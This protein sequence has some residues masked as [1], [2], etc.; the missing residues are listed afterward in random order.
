MDFVGRH[1]SAA[2]CNQRSSEC[3]RGESSRLHPVLVDGFV[4]LSR[5]RHNAPAALSTRRAEIDHLLRNR[6]TP[7]SAFRRVS[8][9]EAAVV[10]HGDR[11]WQQSLH[12]HVRDQQGQEQDVDRNEGSFSGSFSV[13]RDEEPGNVVSAPFLSRIGGVG[14]APRST[15]RP[16]PSLFLFTAT[17]RSRTPNEPANTSGAVPTGVLPCCPTR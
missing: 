17:T 11:R 3:D 4:A 14:V 2:V 1:A 7:L 8:D 15:K 13:W 6:V 16:F 9:C 12:L 5:V 10:L